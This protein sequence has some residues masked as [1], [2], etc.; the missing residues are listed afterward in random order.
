[1][2][3]AT[4]GA[5]KKGGNGIQEINEEAIKGYTFR[6]SA[7]RDFSNDP[8]N[9]EYA[10][11]ADQFMVDH[12]GT[13]VEYL[14][15]GDHQPE[16]IASAIAA[17]DVWDLQYVFT[18]SRL[19]GDIVDGLYEPVDGYYDP[20]DERIDEDAMKSGYFDGHYYGVS[21][22]VMN[23]ANYL[24]YNESL[25]KE[26]GIKT[27]HEY[28][29]ENKWNFDAFMEICKALHEKGF[30]INTGNFLRPD[31]IMNYATD[32]N[33]DYTE[34]E[35]TIDSNETRQILDKY[36]TIIYDYD[37]LAT[38]AKVVRREVAMQAEVMPNLMVGN[39]TTETDDVIRYIYLPSARPEKIGPHLYLTDAQFMTP[40]GSNPDVKAAAV[41]LGICMGASRKAYILDY[42]KK[43][44][45]DEDFEI[46]TKA[47]EDEE[48]LGRGVNGF[49][50][51][52]LLFYDNM[53]SGKPVATYISEMATKM[54]TYADEF[55]RKLEDYR[56]ESGL[57]D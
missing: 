7:Y 14:T 15:V 13:K 8:L 51:T 33:D 56:A 39:L 16:S 30:K 44:M 49:N 21:N 10:D 47:M 41:E 29:K 45:N 28:Y 23:E 11:G 57:E 22:R 24:S 50:H 55:N 40:T 31:W 1:M 32:W 42:Y 2:V 46:L 34:V 3:A 53:K 35:I 25:F 52:H 27:P 20:N 38:K 26:N 37:M 36:R 48:P 18:C 4:F 17:G 43:N 5:C 12:P 54:K 19:P 9:H 6:V